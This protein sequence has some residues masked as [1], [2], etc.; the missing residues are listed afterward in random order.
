[1][2]RS[3]PSGGHS[4]QCRSRPQPASVRVVE[5]GSFGPV[6]KSSSVA[7]LRHVAPVFGLMPSSRRSAAGE[8]CDH[9]GRP[10]SRWRA[11]PRHCSSGGA[12]SPWSL[13]PMAFPWPD[14]GASGTSLPMRLPS[15]PRKGSHHQNGGSNTTSPMPKSGDRPG[16]GCRLRIEED[17]SSV[18]AFMVSQ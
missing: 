9:S 16:G 18:R 10:P 15:I 5:R 4:N 7:H 13:G 17:R 14:R 1:M 11:S 8:A 3:S 2:Q 6:F 12:P